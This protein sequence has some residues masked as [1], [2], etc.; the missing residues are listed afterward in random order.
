MCEFSLFVSG[1]LR[2]VV[3]VHAQSFLEYTTYSSLTFS[4]S[5]TCWMFILPRRPFRLVNIVGEA[6]RIFIVSFLSSL[7][8]AH[9]LS[10]RYHFLQV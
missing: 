9:Y 6:G 10:G 2:T 7:T 8:T 5:I 3:L 4:P 1:R